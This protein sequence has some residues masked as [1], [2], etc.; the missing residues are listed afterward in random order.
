VSTVAAPFAARARLWFAFT[1]PFTL[2]PPTFGVLSGALT[3]FGSAHNPDP[4]RRFTV[5]VAASIALG[6]LCAAL[7]N[8]ASNVINQIHDLEIDRRNKPA[9]PLPSGTISLPAS[10][11]FAA[12]LYALAIVP[13]WMVVIYPR[14]GLGARLTSPVAWHEC[15]FIYLAGLILTFVYS[16]PAWGRT[17]RFGLWANV[18]IA[19]P[20]GCLLKVAGWSMVGSVLHLEPWY[21]GLIFMLFLLGATTSKDFSDMEGDAAHGCR[22]LPIRWGIEKAARFGAPFFVLPWLLIP[23][24]TI[25]RDPFEG[26]PILTGDPTLLTI[27]GGAMASWGAYTAR[28][29]LRDPRSLA[30]TENHPSWTHMYLMMMCAQ[31]GF[32]LAYVHS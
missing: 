26:G 30:T 29:I 21:I 8:A 20:R 10:R 25:L 11:R 4:Q 22:T 32:A 18:T 3:A 5:A 19:V 31:I 2:L 28:L 7:L 9:R 15:F 24:G 16:D 14:N 1:R 27:L 17:K 6:S 13:T 23:L 12:V